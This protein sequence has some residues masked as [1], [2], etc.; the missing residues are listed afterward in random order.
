MPTDALSPYDAVLVLSFGGPERP[1]EVAPFLASVAGGRGI[2]PERLAAVAERY[3]ERGG[4]SPINDES[5]ALV[6]ALRAELTRRGL[7]RPVYL[8]NRH[9]EPSMSQALTDAAGHRRVVA[10]LTSAYP[11]YAGC[12]AYREDLARAVAAL[13]AGTAPAIDKVRPFGLHPAYSATCSRLVTEA[14]RRLLSTSGLPAPDLR[15]VFVAHS[16]PLEQ[17]AGSGPGATPGRYEAWHRGLATAITTELAAT[18][19]VRVEGDVAY[20]S[21]SGPPTQ[22]WLEPSVEDHLEALAAQGVRGVVIAPIGF[23]ADHMEVVYDLDVEA[24]GVARRLGLAFARVPTVR[25]D[26]E[27][28]T[29][30]ADLLLERAAEA[31]GEEPRRPCWPRLGEPAASA[32]PTDCCP[33]PSGRRPSACEAEGTTR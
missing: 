31:R 2:P 29:G 23:V 15:V 17:A 5:R 14:T 7:T 27:F 3:H 25:A 6:A 10:I 30:L 24:A 13:P 16:L 19:G 33:N 11:S 28:V 20:C 21:R 18:L 12:R 26:P 1:Q 8:G 32:C 4:R 22:P 9:L